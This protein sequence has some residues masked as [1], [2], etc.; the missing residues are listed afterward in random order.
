[1]INLQKNKKDIEKASK[2]T[3]VG[4]LYEGEKKIEKGDELIIFK[5]ERKKGEL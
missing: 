5:K 1:L 4:I 2:G 3:E